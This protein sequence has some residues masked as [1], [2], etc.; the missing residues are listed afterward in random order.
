M[1]V[2]VFAG[3]LGVTFFGLVMTPVFY[4]VILSVV[5]RRSAGAQQFALKPAHEEDSRHV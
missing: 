5:E 4:V 1:G 2:A 3:M